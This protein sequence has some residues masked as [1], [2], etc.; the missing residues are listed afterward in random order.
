MGLFA[1]LWLNLRVR[2]R[3]W[4][5]GEA[6]GVFLQQIRAVCAAAVIR[7]RGSQKL[8]LVRSNQQSQRVSLISRVLATPAEFQSFE[9]RRNK[10]RRA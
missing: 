2:W 8:R 4:R 7:P 5:T 9:T 1:L 3:E 10:S 6:D